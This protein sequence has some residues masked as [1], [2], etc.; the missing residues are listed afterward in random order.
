[1]MR[2]GGRVLRLRE[3]ISAF[4]Q[5]PS[6]LRQAGEGA[7]T[8]SLLLFSEILR[9]EHMEGPYP[10]EI[11]SRTGS[12][13]STFRRGSRDNVFRVEARGS[14]I[15]G[16]FGSE[17]RRARV[18]NEGSGYLPGGVIRSSRP[19]GLLAV[20]SD[21]ARTAGGVVMAKYRGPLRGLPNTF[22]RSIRAPKA[23]AAVFERRG[24]IAVPIA[25]LVEGVKI[26][27]RF[28]MEKTL[29]TVEPR[30]PGIFTRRFTQ[31]IDR[32]NETLRRIG[33]R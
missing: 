16:T 6:L 22:V 9:R 1:M 14:T 17:D 27:G 3:T 20:R 10:T 11:Q 4:A 31:V 30:L 26:V 15:T 33:G 8:E 23:K 32:L 19:G 25:W 18:L 13:R 29:R 2:V 7:M 24:K 5:I 28:F 21:F 12:L